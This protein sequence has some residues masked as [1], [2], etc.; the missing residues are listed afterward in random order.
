MTSEFINIL[1]FFLKSLSDKDCL[2]KYKDLFNE[3]IGRTK[4]E[5]EDNNSD[6]FKAGKSQQKVYVCSEYVY[7]AQPLNVS[8]RIN[9]SDY[10]NDI[11]VDSFTMN[12]IMQNMMK[13]I[14]NNFSEIN[15]ENV[16]HPLDLCTKSNHLVM[17]YEKSNFNDFQKFLQMN[18]QDYKTDNEYRDEIINILI[19]IFEVNDKL[20]DICQFQHCDMKCMQI[21]LNKDSDGN[22]TPTLSDFDKSTCSLFFN[23]EAYRIRLVKLDT[24]MMDDYHEN[25]G[26]D[27]IGS[28]AHRK[29]RRS[30]KTRKSKKEEEL[31]KQRGLKKELL[32]KQRGLR[33]NY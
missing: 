26:I 4:K 27:F 28:K 25:S 1:K 13:S 21:L 19:K 30:K 32:R 31:R 14:V 33:K 8:R 12:I 24:P 7:K 10:D 23:G 17:I 22:I 11:K 5:L 16:E 15:S 6:C 20:Y 9:P 3:L 2:S 29:T 18:A